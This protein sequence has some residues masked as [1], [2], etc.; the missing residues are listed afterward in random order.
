M[1]MRPEKAPPPRRARWAREQPEYAF[2]W[3]RLTDIT[4]EIL[5]LLKEHWRELALNQDTVIL[6]PNWE[7]Y[8]VYQEL[9]ILHV[10]T[11]RQHGDLV[12][13]LWLL[14][15]PHLHYASTKYANIDHYWLAPE[16]RSGWLGVRLFRE[17]IRKALELDAKI[18]HG[19]EK[20][21]WKNARNRPVSWLFRRLGFTPIEYVWSL[22]LGD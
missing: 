9:G 16:C 5:P 20:M 3:E 6:D 21:H 10:L 17:A 4:R 7:Q 1:L 22:R 2:G 19:A 15:G 12:G 11:V 18:L 13:Y 14:C 8:F